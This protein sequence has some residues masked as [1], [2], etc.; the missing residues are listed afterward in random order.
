[1][2]KSLFILWFIINPSAKKMDKVMLKNH[3][4][5]HIENFPTPASGLI[6]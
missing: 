6:A 1:M 3:M 2:E 5:S 4:Y